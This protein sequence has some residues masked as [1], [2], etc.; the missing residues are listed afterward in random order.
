MN[1]MCS[2]DARPPAPPHTCGGAATAG[3]AIVLTL[4]GEYYLTVRRRWKTP[5]S[6]HMGE[7]CVANSIYSHLSKTKWILLLAQEAFMLTSFKPCRTVLLPIFTGPP[8]AN[9]QTPP[10]GKVSPLA[11]HRY[12][13]L[14]WLL[15]ALI[16]NTLL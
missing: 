14:L 2:R 5:L 4:A 6:S 13:L 16:F 3:L 8:S 1:A 11:Q 7:P 9:G 10:C 12:S 15:S